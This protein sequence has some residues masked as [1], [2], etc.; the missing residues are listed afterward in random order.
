MTQSSLIPSDA[1]FLK[2]LPAL[3]ERSMIAPIEAGSSGLEIA[4]VRERYGKP[5]LRTLISQMIAAIIQVAESGG[6]ENKIQDTMAM[7]LMVDSVITHYPHMGISEFGTALKNGVTGIYG[8]NYNR[9]TIESVITWCKKY[10]EHTAPMYHEIAYQRNAAKQQAIAAPSPT[11]IPAPDW[12]REATAKKLQTIGKSPRREKVYFDTLQAYC[13]HHQLPH[14]Y[15]TT[16]KDRWIYEAGPE[17]TGHMDQ[18][19][20]ARERAFLAD[21]AIYINTKPNG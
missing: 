4:Q 3:L 6:I 1:R 19:L 14:T 18:Y 2:D 21:N 15:I 12:F 20:T 8:P 17:F 13:D 10:Y 9:I 5:N 7:S 16:L 11:A